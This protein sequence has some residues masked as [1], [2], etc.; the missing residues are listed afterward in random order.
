MDGWIRSFDLTTD[1]GR[2]LYALLVILFG[3]FC[4]GAIGV[5]REM[6]GHAAGLRTHT[7]TAIAGTIVGF[8]TVCYTSNS[9]ALLVGAMI[10]LGFIS[11]GSIFFNGKGVSGTTTSAT[12]FVAGLIGI[13]NGLGYVAESLIG[14][15]FALLVLIML[16]YVEKKTSKSSPTAVFIVNND[17]DF[18]KKIV[19][20][21]T[22]FS[23]T[24]RNIRSEI[25]KYRSQDAIRVSVVFYSAP[26][27]TVKAYAEKVNNLTSPLDYSVKG[28]KY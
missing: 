23:L 21:S 28:P 27:E 25:V 2:V 7:L 24:I 6:N 3:I 10:A 5:E 16:H 20:I 12:V 19:D 8:L 18:A 9:A 17:E 1:S 26:M 14:T 22:E 11:A 15:A 13:S 4:G